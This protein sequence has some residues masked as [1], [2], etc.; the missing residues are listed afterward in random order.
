MPDRRILVQDELAAGEKDVTVRWAM[1]TR[2]EVLLNGAAAL[3]TRNGRTLDIKILD[4]PDT[5][6]E[7]VPADPHRRNT[8]RPIPTRAWSRSTSRSLPDNRAPF[9]CC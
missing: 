2:A 7:I 5:A 4:T 6:I 3:L 1:A 9:A 8:T